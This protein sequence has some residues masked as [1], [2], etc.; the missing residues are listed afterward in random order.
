M[1]SGAQW[2]SFES[3][4]VGVLASPRSRKPG[5]I[6]NIAAARFAERRITTEAVI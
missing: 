1:V 5:V 2:C 6:E 3:F 4:V